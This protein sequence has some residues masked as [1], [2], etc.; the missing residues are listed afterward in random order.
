M[1]EFS[2]S[3]PAAFQNI[4]CNNYYFISLSQEARGIRSI[5]NLNL[6]ADDNS[7]PPL[8]R[9]LAVDPI[10]QMIQR[11]DQDI[12]EL[13]ERLGKKEAQML[14]ALERKE[15]QMKEILE[16]KDQEME[17]KL[18]KKDEAMNKELEN[19]AEAMKEQLE[20]KEAHLTNVEG[21]VCKCTAI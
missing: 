6:M 4:I 2:C 12:R 21:K 14:E 13:K 15:A 8:P 3:W 18:V 7:P 10:Q 19:K 5:S 9:Q 20:K 11:L 17:D 1:L 16:K